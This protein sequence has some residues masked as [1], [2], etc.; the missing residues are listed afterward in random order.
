MG[1][2]FDHHNLHDGYVLVFEYDE[3]STFNMTI[4]DHSGSE[5]TYD[6]DIPE[7][8]DNDTSHTDN[9]VFK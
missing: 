3:K 8:E 4:F 5:V 6:F 2:I 1:A 7:E 9:P